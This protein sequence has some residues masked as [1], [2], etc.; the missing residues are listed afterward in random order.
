M[1]KRTVAASIAHYL[2]ERL[3][4]A[5]STASTCRVKGQLATGCKSP[6]NRAQLSALH[7]GPL[8]PPQTAKPTEAK[9]S[10]T[11]RMPKKTQ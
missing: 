4:L 2:Q 5:P 3:S 6:D 10:P 7:C 9:V 1:L 8:F 11:Y